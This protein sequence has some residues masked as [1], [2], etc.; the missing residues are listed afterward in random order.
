[1]INKSPRRKGLNIRIPIIIPIK[2]KGFINHGPG[3][4]IYGNINPRDEETNGKDMENDMGTGITVVDVIP[5]VTQ[6]Q[7]E[8]NME[9]GMDT[10]RV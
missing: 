8:K 6:H 4:A 5:L 9:N 10:W 7:L 1:M 3:L 2:G